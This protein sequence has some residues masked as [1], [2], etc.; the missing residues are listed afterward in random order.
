MNTAV[1]TVNATPVK[2]QRPRLRRVANDALSTVLNPGADV[3]IVKT[4]SAHTRLVGH[5][6]QFDAGLPHTTA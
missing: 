2:N 3:S 1:A 6:W 4:I 5:S